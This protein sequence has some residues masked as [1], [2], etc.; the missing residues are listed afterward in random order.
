[1]GAWAVLETCWARLGASWSVLVVNIYRSLDALV[2]D[3]S[4]KNV[5]FS[6][7]VKQIKTHHLWLS[8]F[9]FMP[10][11]KIGSPCEYKAKRI[12]TLS[13]VSEVVRTVSKLESLEKALCD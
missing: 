8:F 1:M 12:R 7:Q 9:I 6:I 11:R 10:K 13:N 2:I 5:V 4:T 3:H